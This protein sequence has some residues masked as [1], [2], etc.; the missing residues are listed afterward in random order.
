VFRRDWLE[1][2]HAAAGA[3]ATDDAALV[4]ALGRPVRLTPGDTLN[5]KITT[6]D[7]LR[8]AE[9]WLADHA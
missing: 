8:L 2:A 1:A 7:D 5:F 6:P 4:E 9:A 3:A